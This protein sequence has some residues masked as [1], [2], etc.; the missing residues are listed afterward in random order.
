[1]FFP[2][3]ADIELN[4]LPILTLIVCVACILVFAKQVLSEHSYNNAMQHYCTH[5]T[6]DERLLMRYLVVPADES[7]CDV[8][9]RLRKSPYPK[10]DIKE[11]AQKARPANFYATKEGDLN[12]IINTLTDSLQRFKTS[13]PRN[14]TDKLHFDPNHTTLLSSLTSAFSHGDTSH[15]V[16]NLL[17]FFAFAASVEAITGYAYYFA[18]FVLCA[19]GSD[20]AYAY[21]VRDLEVALPTIGLSGVV[22]A[23]MSFLATVKPTLNIRCFFWFFVFIRR[24]SLPVLVLAALYIC[25]NIYDYTNLDADSHI[26]YVAHLSGA[27]IGVVMGLIYRW[28][29]SLELDSLG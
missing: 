13:V 12:H 25:T 21:S 2:Y 16:F 11:L 6:T 28:R 22:M 7:Y 27:A 10:E 9:I 3:K 14:L 19:I 29:N 26:N 8:L 4:R 20:F 18:F 5:L 24:F 15:L 17:F 1:M 23:M